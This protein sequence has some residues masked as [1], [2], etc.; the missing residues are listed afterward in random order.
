MMMDKGSALMETQIEHEVVRTQE[1]A[2]MLA[3]GVTSC[4]CVHVSPSLCCG[5][6]DVAVVVGGVADDGVAL[7]PSSSY[8]P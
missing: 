2:V 3:E 4:E 6:N 7:Q 1:V 5:E 8:Y